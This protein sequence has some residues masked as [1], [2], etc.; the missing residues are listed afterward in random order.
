MIRMTSVEAQNRFGQL[1][2]TAQ[3]ETVAITRHGRPTAFVV[4]PREMEELLSVR[5]RRS[6]AVAELEAWS[7]QAKKRARPAAARLTDEEV[8]RMVHESR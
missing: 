3:R 5:R 2:D 1:L 7:V 6:K 8:N 4:S